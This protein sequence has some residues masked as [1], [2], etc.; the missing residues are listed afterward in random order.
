MY[1]FPWS[2]TDNP[3]GW[4]EVTDVCNLSCPGCYRSKLGGHVPIDQIK[5]EVVTLRRS[6]NC[7]GIGIAGG[8][9]LLYPHLVEVVEFITRQGLKPRLLTN[10]QNLTWDLARDLKKAGLVNISFHVDSRQ[11]RSGWEGKTES[12]MNRLRQTYADFISELGGVGCGFLTTIYR[13]TIKEI[14]DILSWARQ[15]IPKVG[16]I[17]LIAL[18]GISLTEEYEYMVNG[19]RI[20]L[21]RLR[22]SLADTHEISITAEDIFEVIEGRFPGSHPSAYLNGTAVPESYKVLIIPYLGSKWGIFGRVGSK[23]VEFSQIMHHLLKGRYYLGLRKLVT[24]KEIFLMSLADPEVSKAL[25][26][27]LRIGLRNPLMFFDPLYIQT[28]QIQQPREILDGETNTCDGCLN[29][30]IYR[31]KIINSCRLDEYRLYGGSL[32]PMKAPPRDS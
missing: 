2:R 3:G 20:D 31:G 9:P 7:D 21:W 1:R 26:N 4:V 5:S 27:W 28:V 18:R 30:M 16:S 32:T 10:G 24:G 11:N 12:E 8:E 22:T 6:L 19:Q 13:S 17:T 15:N 14:P 25:R 23:T 29:Q